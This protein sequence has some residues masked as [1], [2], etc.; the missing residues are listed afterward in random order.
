MSTSYSSSSKSRYEYGEWIPVKHCQCGLE[1]KLLTTWKHDNCG[2]RFWKCVGS[3]RCQGCGFM[4]WF[5]P[6][7]CK[8]SQKIIPGLLK[9]LNGYEDQMQL[10]HL[11]VEELQE[12]EKKKYKMKKKNPKIIQ[13][14]CFVTI[15]IF[16]SMYAYM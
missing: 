5:D 1:M 15:V 7:M 8:R 9:K 12:N 13:I 6:P 11:K 14:A 10:L 4:D 16:V 3:E 2:R